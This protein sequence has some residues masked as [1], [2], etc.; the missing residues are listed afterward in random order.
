[1]KGRRHYHESTADHALM[2]GW[3]P[4]D[5]WLVA[6]LPLPGIRHRIGSD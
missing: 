4:P 2:T 1:M 6:E 5:R 3:S